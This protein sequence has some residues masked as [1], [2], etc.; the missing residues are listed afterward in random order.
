MG[1]LHANTVQLAL[2]NNALRTCGTVCAFLYTCQG[3][4]APLNPGVAFAVA[5]LWAVIHM[6]PLALLLVLTSKAAMLVCVLTY[7]WRCLVPPAY[8]LQVNLIL[9]SH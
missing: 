6:Q 2:L 5:L 4:V 1:P 3:T 7:K 8:Q 9:I